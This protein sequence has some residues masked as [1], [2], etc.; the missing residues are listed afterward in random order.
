LKRFLLKFITYTMAESVKTFLAG[1]LYY[2][3][4]AWVYSLFAPKGAAVL[5][6]H[7]VGTNDVFWDNKVPP[8]VFE[9]QVAYLT[10]YF[11]VVPL[12]DI[13]GRLAEGGSVPRDWVAITFDDGYKDNADVALPI[14]LK[15]GATASFFVTVGVITGERPFFYD[16]AQTIIE[17][18]DVPAVTLASQGKTVRYDLSTP[19]KKQDS[20]LRMVLAV[21]PENEETR[22]TF[23]RE[24]SNRCGAPPRLEHVYMDP[25]DL[26]RLTDAGAEVG[27]H[28]LTHANLNIL[29]EEDL[30]RELAE[31]KRF[32]E[33]ATGRPV[34]G[35]AYPFGKPWSY[36][37]RVATAARRLGYRYALTTRHGKIA[38]GA[39]PFNLPRVTARNA[40]L[41][42]LKVSLMGIPL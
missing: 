28:T 33:E 4:A 13:L 42:R 12:A 5:I 14:L 38:A 35:L 36:S 19:S 24:L 17:R 22:Q 37:G 34:T 39:D 21:R 18:T 25:G 30:D 11:R 32:I 16:A 41:C 1:V 20:I 9:K 6:Y 29:S 2:S 3:G 23:V 26:R 40:A 10:K 27:S 31:S 8:A 15:H 7:S